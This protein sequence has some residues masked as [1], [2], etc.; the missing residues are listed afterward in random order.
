M[1]VIQMQSNERYR[2]ASYLAEMLGELKA[3]AMAARL[4]DL[5]YLT[6]LAEAEAKLHVPDDPR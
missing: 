1:A 6:A 4:H 2:T 3:L 5:A